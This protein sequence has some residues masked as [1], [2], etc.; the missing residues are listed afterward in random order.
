VRF[1]TSTEFDSYERKRV[2]TAGHHENGVALLAEAVRM[3]LEGIVAKRA[4]STYTAGRSRQWLKIK[5]RAGIKRERGR[6]AHLR[7]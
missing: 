1:D 5:T 4:D 6:L 7:R 2:K 3:E